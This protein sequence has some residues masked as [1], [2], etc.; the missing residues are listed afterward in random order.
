MQADATETATPRRSAGATRE[1]ILEATNR[2][3]YTEGIR[4]TSADRIIEEVG[5]TKVTFYRHFRSKSD[6]VVAYLTHQ[7]AA[8]REWFQGMR[9]A[10]DPLGSLHA[11]AS[12]I[13]A[14]SCSPGFRGCAFI[15]AAAE[16]SDPHDPVRAVVDAHRQWMLET[17][18]AIAADAGI[19]DT[20]GTARQLMM[21][22]DGAM[23]NGYL[24]NPESVAESLRG[25]F[26]SVLSATRD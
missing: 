4:A 14:A 17:F 12:G 18:A 26:D 23:V 1:R 6:L 5:I 24:G 11:I 15:N 7:A 10:D 22:R 19:E 8:E 25:A 16:F 9:R 20:E 2:L 3:F 13:G 21:V